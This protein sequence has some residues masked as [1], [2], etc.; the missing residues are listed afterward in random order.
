MG[1]LQDMRIAALFVFA[2][3]LYG[4]SFSVAFA[5]RTGAFAESLNHPAIL[6]STTAA[7]TVVDE[8]N[9]KL[10]DGSATLTFDPQSGYLK[11]V[12]DLL[13]VPVESQVLVYTQTSQQA[14]KIFP[15][16]PRAIYFNDNVS[17]GYVRGGGILE[18]V[19]QD[20]RLGSVFYVIHQ[21]AGARNI[22]R[23]SQCLRCH[24]SWDTLGVPGMSVLS[25]F[26]RKSKDDY[27]NGFFVDHYRPIEGRWGGWYVTGK[28][29][30][31]RHM[32]NFPLIMPKPPHEGKLSPPPARTSLEGQFDLTSYPT[33]YSDIVALMVLEHQAHA[34]NLITRANWEARLNQP[35][36][37]DSA[38]ESRRLAQGKRVTEAIDTLVDYLL[39]VD[40]APIPAGGI[41]GSSGFAERF[42]SMGPRDSKGRSLRDFELNT[43]LM[44]YP[45]SYMIYS[46]AFE[47]LPADVK[48]M[49]LARVRKILAGEITGPKYTFLTPATRQAIAEILNETM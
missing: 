43:R 45:L 47:A 19:A 37:F 46:P 24:L 38:S 39:F 18:I 30:P 33:P 44:K 4:A 2:A 21:D 22:G 32:G 6:Y 8:L 14:E 9:R 42:Q 23:E 3:A 36:P 1:C 28:R 34:A 48:Q 17:V 29:V 41:E 16:N 27:A 49:A 25:T 26:P 35:S 15:E 40:E 12:L 5:Q 7:N 20:A 10:A 13:R 31:A 11:S